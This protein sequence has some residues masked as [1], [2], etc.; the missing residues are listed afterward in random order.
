MNDIA[1]YCAGGFGKEVALLVRRINEAH[2]K[3]I[4]N[5]IGFFDD[6]KPSGY[7]VL[8]FGK[9]LGGINELNTWDKPLSVAIAIGDPEIKNKIHKNITNKLISFPNLIHP[10]FDM[11]DSESFA[12]GMGNII[13]GNCHVTCDVSI[14]N[15][16]ILNGSVV[17]G[18]DVRIG[19]YN[20]LMADIRISGEVI[21]G[22]RNLFGV[23]SI[24][25]QRIKIGTSV[26]LSPG[27]VLITKPKDNSVYIGNPARLFKF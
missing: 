7:S 20:S 3:P 26:R 24:V 19:N 18:H 6:A 13:Q 14:G 21:I 1:I 22:D 15:F 25:L 5:M 12:I 2:E 10:S 17:I 8:R 27:S 23:G 4:W 16:N 11:G 9:V